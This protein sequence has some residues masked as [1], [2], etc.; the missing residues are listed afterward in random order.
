[1]KRIIAL[2]LSLVTIVC[3]IPLVETHGDDGNDK[4]YISKTGDLWNDYINMMNI[5][6]SGGTISGL[7][8]HKL[9]AEYNSSVGGFVVVEK[10][11]SH[12]S[13]TKKVGQ[14][15]IGLCFSYNPE[16]ESGNTF[17]KKNFKIWSKIRVGDVLIPNGLDFTNKTIITEGN[18]SEGTFS[19]KSYFTVK[20]LKRNTEPTAYAGKTI[21]ALGDSTTCNGGWTEKISDMLGCNVINAGVSANRTKE[22][23]NRFDRDVLPFSPDIVLIMFGINDCVQYY[24]SDKT[25]EI[26][27]DELHQLHSRCKTIG[28][29]PIFITPNNINTES[30]NYDRYKN[31]GGLSECYPKF[32]EA[33][34]EVAY[35]TDSHYIDIYANFVYD[36]LLCDS[37]HPNSKGYN[38]F[39]ST[40]SNYMINYAD[41][42]CAKFMAGFV[43]SGEGELYISDGCIYINLCK[44]KDLKK[45]FCNEI[46]VYSDNNNKLKDDDFLIENCRVCWIDENQSERDFISINLIE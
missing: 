20:Y 21:V 5:V 11:A 16:Y 32:I 8:Y 26:F 45:Y 43:P 4:I 41:V 6:F 30:L 23:L 2:I 7:Y 15:A 35:E 31:Y 22:A 24:Y 14:N 13:Y 9:Y 28:A 36:D 27:K 17:G 37:V 12:C 19:T 1:M 46:V 42:I 40:I 10:V 25:V 44:V 38:I 18:L 33:I 39:I 34:K 29:I 3:F